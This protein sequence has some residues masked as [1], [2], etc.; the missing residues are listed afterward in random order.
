MNRL[1]RKQE[2]GSTS[3]LTLKPRIDS[4]SQEYAYLSVSRSN[5]SQ[6]G[7]SCLSLTCTGAG[8][9]QRSDRVGVLSRCLGLLDFGFRV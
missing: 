2:R 5:S 1:R 9:E 7:V 6:P 3:A 8:K 4:L